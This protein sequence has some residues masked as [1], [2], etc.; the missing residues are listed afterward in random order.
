MESL[1]NIDMLLANMKAGN[2]N[3][4]NA[5]QKLANKYELLDEQKAQRRLVEEDYKDSSQTAAAQEL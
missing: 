5:I 4:E 1:D 3:R 2:S